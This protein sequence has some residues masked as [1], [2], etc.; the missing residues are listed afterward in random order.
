VGG[1]GRLDLRAPSHPGPSLPF[2]SKDSLKAEGRRQK[3]E[4]LTTEITEVTEKIS[5]CS[6][7]SVVTSF[8]TAVGREA[9]DAYA[10]DDRFENSQRQK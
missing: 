8:L 9:G 2:R 1:G 5:V 10:P 6:V 7:I 3:A 4:E